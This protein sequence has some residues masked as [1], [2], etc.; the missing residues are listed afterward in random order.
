MD[1]IWFFILFPIKN[2]KTWTFVVSDCKSLLSDLLIFQIAIPIMWYKHFFCFWVLPDVFPQSDILHFSLRSRSPQLELLSH[3]LR[4]SLFFPA[5]C[6]WSF[7]HSN[8]STKEPFFECFKISAFSCL[9]QISLRLFSFFLTA[10][11]SVLTS[12]LSCLFPIKKTWN[13]FGYDHTHNEFFF[14]F[15][16]SF[17][18]QAFPY[19]WSFNPFSFSP[20]WSL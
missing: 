17:G 5:Y 2:Y 19:S 12:A 11:I 10:Q 16:V 9:I 8:R 7:H 14:I 3:F 15:S 6:P 13:V 18:K 1:S 20:L 4:F